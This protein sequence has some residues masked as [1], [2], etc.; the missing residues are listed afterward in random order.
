MGLTYENGNGGL[1]GSDALASDQNIDIQNA[2]LKFK[3]P[4]NVVGI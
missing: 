2:V 3:A 4:T 1:S